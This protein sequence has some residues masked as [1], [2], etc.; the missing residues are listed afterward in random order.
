MSSTVSDCLE[1]EYDPIVEYVIQNNFGPSLGGNEIWNRWLDNL[2][3]NGYVT[4]L[5]VITLT[6]ESLVAMNFPKGNCGVWKVFKEY[7]RNRTSHDDL[8]IFEAPEDFWLSLFAESL[9]QV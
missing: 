3:N 4:I 6:P 1:I 7:V 5:D 9:H 2:Y 8:E